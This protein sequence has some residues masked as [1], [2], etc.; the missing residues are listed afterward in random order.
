MSNTL[1]GHRG[2]LL[3]AIIAALVLTLSLTGCSAVFRSS[4]QGRVIDLEDWDNGT[5]TG[6]EDATV[7]LYTDQK[8][9]DADLVAFVEGDDATRPDGSS[10]PERLYFQ[11]T[12]T[13]TNGAY[14]FT[15]FIW[16]S[17]F[18]KYGKTADR[19]EVF[20]LIYHPDYGLK[21]NPTPLYVVSDV[22]N[23]LDLLK[24]EDLWNEGRLAGTVLDWKDDKGLD[25]VTV[26]FYVA[27]SW[28]YDAGGAFADVVY[29]TTP[30]ATTTTAP[31][32]DGRWTATV[33][34]PM[35]PNRTVHATHNNA[36]VRVAFVLN[37]YRA[38][39]PADGSG[40][41]NVDLVSD[42]DIDRDGRTATDGD[43]KDAFVS[44]TLE[45]DAVAGEAKIVTVP[46]ISLQ[47]WRFSAAVR[48]RTYDTSQAGYANGVKVT[49]GVPD[50]LSGTTYTAYS[51]KQVN[52]TI[53]T[54]GVFDL[55]TIQWKMSDIE[56]VEA[57]QKA[58]TVAIAMQG[59]DAALSSG[60]PATLS[61]DATLVL[62][63]VV[64]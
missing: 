9:R 15:G 6:V 26:N 52:G 2:R 23:Q 43:Y 3:A 35:K 39:D 28:T 60:N 54:D 27:K 33:R 47:R 46:A 32:G 13:D 22:T 8:A 64:P 29:P 59:N 58:G 44:A 21:P 10:R 38:N 41:S 19:N 49:L 24:I 25:G 5:T 31:N 30:S 37:N 55:G 11:S 16:E 40:L 62:E 63:L 14:D 34:F 56:A 12:V 57:T 17:L 18:P 4:I 1:R 48:G 36:P 45:Y 61:P 42:V 51:E 50:L 53:E 20:L 7:F